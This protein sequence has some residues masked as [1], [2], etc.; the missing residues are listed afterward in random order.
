MQIINFSCVEKLPMLL[1]PKQIDI[2]TIRPAWEEYWKECNSCKGAGSLADISKGF[3][4]A[5]S[6]ICSNCNGKKAFL[7]MKEKPPRFKVGDNVQLF[8]KQRCKYKWFC[9]NCGNGIKEYIEKGDYSMIKRRG[10]GC[11]NQS[12]PFN[13]LLG[14]AKT[15]EVFKIEIGVMGFDDS[16]SGPHN[17]Y[18]I[19]DDKV[20][21]FSAKVEDL[22][23]RDGF[24]SAED[25]FQYFDSNYDLSSPKPFYVYRGKKE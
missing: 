22:V 9:S 11:D 8:W 13:K 7:K 6:V 15:I 10:C 16:K 20:L 2:Q 24:S 25:F 21:W 14:T 4:N 5:E 17:E 1:D 18:Y 23:K 3:N 12:T 19:R